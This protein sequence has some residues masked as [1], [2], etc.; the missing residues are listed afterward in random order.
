MISS[1]RKQ[2]LIERFRRR[3]QAAVERNTR[4]DADQLDVEDCALS[5][6]ADQWGSMLNEA[7]AR[8]VEN[9]FQHEFTALFDLEGNEV[10]AK[11]VK[12]RFGYRWMVMDE[13]GDAVEWLPLPSSDRQHKNLEKKGYRE[14]TVKRTA[15][16]K[17]EGQHIT[18]LGLCYFPVDTPWIAAEKDS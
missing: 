18:S 13:N 9:D 2:E 7:K 11:M 15:W 1:E 5:H 17:L 10:K 14:G 8:L 16:V 6:F 4:R 3:S 12:T